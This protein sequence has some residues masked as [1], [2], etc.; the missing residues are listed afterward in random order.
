M[1][2]AVLGNEHFD[3][4]NQRRDDIWVLGSG[5]ECGGAPSGRRVPR[6]C[7]NQFLL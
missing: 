5:D 1:L 6:D 4:V 3:V 2:S 7:I